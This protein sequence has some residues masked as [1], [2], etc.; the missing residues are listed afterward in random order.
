MTFTVCCVYA[1]GGG[2]DDDLA[3]SD[4]VKKTKTFLQRQCR[5]TILRA[6]W[7]SLSG[8]KMISMLFSVPPPTM[9]SR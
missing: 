2:K 8:V 5:W 7:V 4:D 6:V 1:C 3:L 9:V